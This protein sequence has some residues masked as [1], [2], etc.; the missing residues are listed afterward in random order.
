MPRVVLGMSVSHDTGAVILR[1]GEMVAAINEER[2]TRVKQAVGAPL[3][4]VPAIL[5]QTGIAASEIDAVALTGRIALGD[6]PVNSDWT[7]EDGSISSAQRIAEALDALPGGPAIMRSA[8]A[9]GAY[10]VLM[11]HVPQPRL[12]EVHQLLRRLGVR[13]DVAGGLQRF[14]HH[15]AHLASAYYA[16]GETDCLVVSNDAFGD[17]LCCKVAV[18]RGGRLTVI[19]QNSFPNSLGCYY[20]YATSL[21]GFR[22][23]HHA[24]KTT[25]LAA[26]GNPDRTLGVFRRLLSWDARRGEYVN[27]GPIFGRALRLM[28]DEL[29]GVSREDIAAGIQRH[30]QDVL[31]AQVRHFMA[32]TGLR[33]VVLAGGLH[34]NV[35]ANQCIAEIENLERLFVYPNMGDGG[36]AA[37]AAWMAWAGAQAGVIDMPPRVRHV[38]LGSDISED[39]A[40]AALRAA[41]L[42][43]ER[44]ENLARAVAERLA[45]NKIVARASG[46]MEFGPRALG[47]RSIL[48]GANDRSVNKWLNDQLKRT[49]F[50]PFAPVCRDVDV[51]AFFKN[52]TPVTSHTAEFMTVTYDA[53]ERCKQEAPATVHVDGTAR[54]QIVRREINPE[55]YD[56]LTEYNR[57]TGLS[58]LVNT[59]FN[60]HEEPIIRTASEAVAAFFESHIDSL[61]LGPFL[62]DNPNSTR[63]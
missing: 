22:K 19:S 42:P 14:D 10:R 60:M 50:M 4:S 37:G 29:A 44:P 24:G 26:F 9:V 61:A 52:V 7:F 58:I 46:P 32:V 12:A 5:E 51:D 11:P 15:D 23:A 56:I 17:G 43:V 55:Y 1:D 48:Y 54:P 21:C 20:S 2:L 62:A 30:T 27:H 39:D 16:S 8:L 47:N 57:L 34:A 33:K 63:G 45:A 13:S 40:A 18:G 3:Q 31:V 36:L 35:R 41:T 38:Y 6:M 25:G 53:T 28:K 59:S 49:E